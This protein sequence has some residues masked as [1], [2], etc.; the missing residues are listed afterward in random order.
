MTWVAWRQQR[1]EV[2]LGAILL[3]VLA[4]LFVPTGMRMA[5]AYATDGASRC[6][7]AP[8]AGCA[9]LLDAFDGR[10]STIIGVTG[11]FALLPVVI[12]VVFAAPFALELERGTYRL[13]WTQSLIRRRWLAAKLLIALGGA[14]ISAAVIA[15]LLTWW[16]QPLDHFHGRIEPGAFQVEGIAPIAYA[17]FAAALIIALGT[18]LRRTIAAIA[19]GIVAFLV[20]RV[21]IETF[22]RPHFASPLQAQQGTNLDTAWVVDGRNYHPS[23][24]FWE[25]QGI[26]T[27]IYLVLTL[28]LLWL[29]A[30][31]ID[32]RVS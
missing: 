30:W 2:V 11:W 22:V 25:F 17:I 5:D 18:I 7:A 16:R 29:V 27:G 12:A 26:E 15:L 28:A 10:F 9:E 3:A 6:V 20:T 21:V 32:H 19:I 31:W 23:S 4:A 1:A 8:A 14:G 13:A 24:R